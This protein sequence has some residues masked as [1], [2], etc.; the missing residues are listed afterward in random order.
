MDLGDSAGEWL[1]NVLPSF[2]LG[3]ISENRH[4]T[5]VAGDDP[6]QRHFLFGWVIVF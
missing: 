5:H 4:D 6:A 3:R 1:L 2:L